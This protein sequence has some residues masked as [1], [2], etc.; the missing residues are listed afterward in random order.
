[1]SRRF[2]R[3]FVFGLA[4]IQCAAPARNQPVPIIS[5]SAPLAPPKPSADERFDAA[6]KTFLDGYLR[7]E[8]VEATELGMHAYDGDWPDRSADAVAEEKRFY[9]ATKAELD[10]IPTA[11]LSEDRRV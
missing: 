8:P 5:P 3:A 9:A 1:M 2:A 4:T 7:R 6:W 10:A 11:E